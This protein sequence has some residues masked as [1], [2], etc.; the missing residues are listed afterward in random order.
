MEKITFEIEGPA[1]LKP[2]RIGDNR[3]YFS[4]TY[5]KSWFKENVANVEFV[6]IN[7]SFSKKSG[8]MRGLHFQDMPMGQGKL[9][10]CIA[11][12]LFD[13]AVDIRANSPTFGRYVSVELDPESGHQFWVPEGF[14]HGFCTLSDSS[15]ISYQVS[16]YYSFEHDNCISYKDTQIG[17]NWPY[18][19]DEMTISP[20]DLAAKSLKQYGAYGA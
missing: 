17:I 3:G 15:I 13:V 11:G 19:F 6:Q 4:E 9:V 1:L 16:Q 20:K 18:E 14:A 10:S 8:T 5:R 7:Q 12:K 2:Q